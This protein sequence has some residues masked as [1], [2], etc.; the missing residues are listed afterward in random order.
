M[1]R[2]YFPY[3]SSAVR[4]LAAGGGDHAYGFRARAAASRALRRRFRSRSFWRLLRWPGDGRCGGGVD[5]GTPHRVVPGPH[6][7]WLDRGV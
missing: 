3:S 4:D 5:R 7:V 2:A 1:Y 6:L